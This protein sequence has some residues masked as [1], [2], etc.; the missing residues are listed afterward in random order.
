MSTVNEPL[1]QIWEADSNEPWNSFVYQDQ[2]FL[3]KEV[4]EPR[5]QA[6]V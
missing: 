2:E 1:V 5:L 4:E 6:E 3:N